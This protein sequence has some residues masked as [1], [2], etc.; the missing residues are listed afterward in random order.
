[1]KNN[2]SVDFA[3][4][5]HIKNDKICKSLYDNTLY[6]FYWCESNQIIFVLHYSLSYHLL[7]SSLNQEMQK[8]RP[9]KINSGHSPPCPPPA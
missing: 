6:I 4:V 3:T 9:L 5:L 2:I 1:M 8:T 7:L